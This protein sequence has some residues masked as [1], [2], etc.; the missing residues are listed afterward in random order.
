MKTMWG[1]NVAEDIQS[2]TEKVKEEMQQ[3]HNS[4]FCLTDPEKSMY[5]TVD[6]CNSSFYLTL[7]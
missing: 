5:I 3:N 4:N 6:M 2:D 1:N 7:E